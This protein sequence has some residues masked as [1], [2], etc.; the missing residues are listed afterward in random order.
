MCL[1][2]IYT[3]TIDKKYNIEKRSRGVRIPTPTMIYPRDIIFYCIIF[4]IVS[5]TKKKQI[6]IIII[7]TNACVE[8]QIP[9]SRPCSLL[10]VRV[11]T[12]TTTTIS[13]SIG[14]FFTFIKKKKLYI[15]IL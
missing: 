2:P 8:L 3:Y 7:I 11:Y 4:N 10:F 1:V 6:I 15:Y 13:C 14:R 5:E 12:T 9:P